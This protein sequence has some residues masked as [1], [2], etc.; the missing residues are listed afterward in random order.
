MRK[1]LRSLFRRKPEFIGYQDAD[2]FIFYDEHPTITK[3][4]NVRQALDTYAEIIDAGNPFETVA[5]DF[6]ADLFHL[7]SSE[8]HDPEELV[9]RALTHYETEHNATAVFA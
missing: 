2:G 7:I 8:G 9:S 4:E 5:S 3:S 6:L 1:I